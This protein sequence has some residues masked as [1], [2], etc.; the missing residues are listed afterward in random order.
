MRRREFFAA[1]GLVALLSTASCSD[2]TPPGSV[3]KCI[4]ENYASYNP[5]N[6]DQC[7]AACIKCEKGVM[8]TCATACSLR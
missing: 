7:I 4:A 6:R 3:S 5:R 2:P 1:V 8:T